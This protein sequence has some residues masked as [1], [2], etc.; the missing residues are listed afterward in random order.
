MGASQLSARGEGDVA[1][2]AGSAGPKEVPVDEIKTNRCYRANGRQ[3]W[4][5]QRAKYPAIA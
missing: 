3:H 2:P 1:D 5:F 4:P